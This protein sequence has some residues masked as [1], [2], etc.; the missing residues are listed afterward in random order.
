MLVLPNCNGDDA[1]VAI[2]RVRNVIQNSEL[3]IED[4]NIKVTMTFGVAELSFRKG[5]D[6][7]VKEADEKLYMGKQSGRN[8]V[9]Y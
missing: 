2:E 1:Y 6:F 7:T 8:K 4:Y 9:V 3:K 5:V